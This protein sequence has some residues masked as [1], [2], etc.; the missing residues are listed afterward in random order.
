M[1]AHEQVD[2]DLHQSLSAQFVAD[3]MH[4]ALD[5]HLMALH[6]RA[7]VVEVRIGRIQSPEPSAANAWEVF[8]PLKKNYR[9]DKIIRSVAMRIYC[10]YHDLII[11]DAPGVPGARAQEFRRMNVSGAIQRAKDILL[12]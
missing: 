12:S 3:Q 7:S 8:I 1:S 6:L 4:R 10:F 2:E 9:R 11:V 5:N